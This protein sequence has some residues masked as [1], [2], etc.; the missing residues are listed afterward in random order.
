LRDDVDSPDTFFRGLQHAFVHASRQNFR[1][2][3]RPFQKAELAYLLARFGID[4]FDQLW[5]WLGPSLQTLRFVKGVSALWSSGLIFGFARREEV[6]SELRKHGTGACIVRFSER[7]PG[8]LGVAYCTTSDEVKHYLLRSKD[9]KL[10][11]ADFL[12][13]NEQFTS[14]ITYAKEKKDKIEV[15]A[16]FAHKK[17]RKKCTANSGY[18][19]LA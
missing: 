15:L 10:S 1:E 6:E 7:F 17:T 19:P 14:I 12:L 2:I 18:E 13:A 9:L 5:D 3:S 4:H 8:R 11:L 16:S